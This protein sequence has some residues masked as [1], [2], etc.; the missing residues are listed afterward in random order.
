MII[1]YELTDFI[2]VIRIKMFA[3]YAEVLFDWFCKE[4]RFV[5]ICLHHGAVLDNCADPLALGSS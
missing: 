1:L 3:L 5:C 4:L 2:E